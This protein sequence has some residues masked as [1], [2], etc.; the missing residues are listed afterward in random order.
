MT[1]K[2]KLHSLLINTLVAD[3]H[4]SATLKNMDI[5]HLKCWLCGAGLMCTYCNMSNYLLNI[6]YNVRYC[7]SAEFCSFCSNV[8]LCNKCLYN[9]ATNIN[10]FFKYLSFWNCLCNACLCLLNPANKPRMFDFSNHAGNAACT[11]ALTLGARVPFIK[12]PV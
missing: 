8:H 4:S 12:V 6:V 10:I 11:G 9:L 2:S 7:S 3:L 5:M 1:F